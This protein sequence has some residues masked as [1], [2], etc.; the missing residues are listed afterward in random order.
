[1]S[2]TDIPTGVQVTYSR[3]YRRCGKAGCARC[4]AGSRGHGPYWYA[5]WWADGRTR[6]C[7]LG[8]QPPA[9]IE[10]SDDDPIRAPAL[11]ADGA[12]L[13]HLRV[14]ILGEFSVRRGMT[15]IPPEA[16]RSHRA[17]ALF[18]CLLSAP[19][20][21]LRREQVID[22][23]WPEAEPEAGATNLRTTTHLLRQVLD[24]PRAG[25]S[26]LR[27]EG[28]LLVLAPAGDAIPPE[29]WLDAT[30]FAVA[31]ERALAGQDVVPCRSALALYGGEYLPDDPYA[32]W[33]EQARASLRR[34]HLDLL[35]HLAIL[36]AARGDVQEAEDCLR[37]VLVDE[38]GHEGAAATL[39]GLLAASG[40][41]GEALQVYQQLATV[42][43]EDLDVAP[44]FEIMALRARLQAQEAAPVAAHTPPREV[45]PARP[46]NLPLALTSF[47]GREWE[48]RAVGEALTAARLVTLTGPGG[49][50][51]TRLALA[52]ADGLVE[53][54]P[55]GVWLVEL[56]AL[57][58]AALAPLAVR[59]ALGVAE[60]PGQGSLATLI[61]F[62]QPRRLLLILD[63]CEHLIGA[64]ADL[65]AALLGGCPY[66]RLL[67]TS[68]EALA[69]AGEHTYLVP[70][71]AAPDPD[72]LPPLE[73]L[74][75]YEAVALFLVRA[76]ARR[77]DLTVT[78]ANAGA[79]AQICA[80][81]DGLPLA[82]ELAA[83]RVGALPI[84]GIAARLDDRF[85]LL[86]G[87]PR[88]A[89]P[90][91]Q[92]LRATLDW[93]YRL[94]LPDEQT[95]LSRLAAFAG[96]CTPAGAA[97][98]CDAQGDHEMATL[99]GMTS[100]ANKG[101]LRP[102]AGADGE[103]RFVMLE[104]IRAYATERLEES[105]DAETVRQRHAT[106]Y[107]A[108]AEEAELKH[109]G[110]RQ[111][112]WLERL[113]NEH[114]NIRAALR[115][116]LD[117]GEAEPRLRL[118]FAMWRFWMLHSRLREGRRWLE[119][120]LARGGAAAPLL[121]AKVLYGAGLLAYRSGDF[122]QAGS[123]HEEGLILFRDGEDSWGIA[124]SLNQLANVAFGADNDAERAWALYRESLRLA[125]E[126]GD[127][128]LS[129][130]ILSN[131]SRVE[132]LNRRDYES[133]RILGEDSLELR[134]HLGDPWSIAE[135]LL[136][137]AWVALEQRD[138]RR[139]TTLLQE[140]VPLVCDLILA[141]CLEALAAA[142]GQRG[143]PERAARLWA[144][145]ETARGA[146]GAPLE[147]IERERNDR[148]L[149]TARA[150]VPEAVWRAAWNEGR[151]MTLEQAIAHALGDAADAE[152]DCI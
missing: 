75:A 79:V 152:Q 74:P 82:I 104:T 37:E 131:M 63:N 61:A 29:D 83:A 136:N 114:E 42:L 1:M 26:Y 18:K 98:V 68:R 110:P 147:R 16:W 67:A 31:A 52:V 54:Y 106:Y 122:V 23:L 142:G 34:Q 76:R 120:V 27:T 138:D 15:P 130:T 40:R 45:Q 44:A 71:L 24:S 88:T 121:R 149:A 73:Q 49:A 81:L 64:C 2:R 78:A 109:W 103:P 59:L 57:A 132:A 66:L 7:Y 99:D 100:L 102:I 133:A 124:R 70:S 56:A 13:E 65:A 10:P 92:T 80:R 137:L 5:K 123:L 146:A 111:R 129:A 51:K 90:R 101:L 14:R 32:P 128:W 140:S 89:L 4:A 8:K 60:Q 107:V 6:S 12:A 112:L 41:R 19:G 143:Q 150:Q 119:E 148:W 145:A 115:R 141:D 69:V 9:Q 139:A 77:P 33:A 125:R 22:L 47:V 127:R 55:D 86:T 93:S 30:A 113:E 144:A 126:M 72:H 134:R 50:G 84:E 96:G 3:Q 38:P 85:R 108:L 116:L 118:A 95:L 117:R 39:M 17:M 35:L 28:D 135:S 21:R 151:N 53:D 25:A 105:G 94:L 48:Q 62:L 43:E 87:G 97:A 36:S 91:Q 11:A 46:T 58:E 20:R